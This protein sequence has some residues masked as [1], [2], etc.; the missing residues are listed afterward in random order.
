MRKKNG[1]IKMKRLLSH[2][3]ILILKD[4]EWTALRDAYLGTDGD[5]II[6][7]SET[8][9]DEPWDEEKISGESC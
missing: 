3:D 5:T 9:P 1:G 8:R 4:G 2:A 6:R 7:I